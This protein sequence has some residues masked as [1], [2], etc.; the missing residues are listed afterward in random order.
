MEDMARLLF[1]GAVA[2][3]LCLLAVQGYAQ[4]RP[5]LDAG[6]AAQAGAPHR[7]RLILKDGSYQLVMSYQVK[8]K[9]VT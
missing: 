8:G 6:P 9:I 1:G 7:T 3:C 4:Q 2:L 5:V